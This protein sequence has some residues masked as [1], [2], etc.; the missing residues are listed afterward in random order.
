MLNIHTDTIRRNSIFAFALIAFSG[1]TPKDT[2]LPIE[3]T[4]V[5]EAPSQDREKYAGSK[6]CISCH[7]EIAKRYSK[8]PMSQSAG[9]ISSQYD[10]IETFEERLIEI[11]SKGLVYEV[12]WSDRGEMTHTERTMAENVHQ[13]GQ[14]VAIDFYIGSG[15]RGRSYLVQRD[16]MLFQSPLT[17]YAHEER[18]D[19][20]PGYENNN[21]H[22]DRRISATCI[23]CHFGRANSIAGDPSRFNKTEVFAEFGIGC[24]NCHGPSADHVAWHLDEEKD[25]ALNSDPIL[26]ISSLSSSK[27]N[28][29]C[30]QC[31][32][33][34]ED[35]ILRRNRSSFD[36]R[37]GEELSDTWVCFVDDAPADNHGLSAVSHVEQMQ[38]SVC[39]AKSQGKMTCVSCHDP[40][41]KPADSEAISFY[42]DKCLTCHGASSTQCSKPELERIKISQQ[43]VCADCH[44]PKQKAADVVHT[45][46]TDHRIL[47]AY[48]STAVSSNPDQ[49]VDLVPFNGVSDHLS[50][51]SLDRAT[52]IAT[53][54]YCIQ[55]SDQ[56]TALLLLP[57]LE[58]YIAK[59]PD[60]IEALFTTGSLHYLVRDSLTAQ[61]RLESV[62]S[63]KADHE[64]ALRTLFLMAHESNSVGLGIVYG[65][66]FLQINRW[67]ANVTGRLIHLLGQT[68]N[69]EEA[70]AL[71]KV[72]VERFPSDH[73]IKTWLNNANAF[74]KEKRDSQPP[75]NFRR[76]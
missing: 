63:L 17:W 76:P 46:L 7:S 75:I 60:D 52:M 57:M 22:F 12:N 36:F 2:S 69:L 74:V 56:T 19:L 44:M 41:G 43:D 21:R 4:V 26:K 24:E 62:L 72:A 50:R 31:H 49:L 32:L 51:E 29:V 54:R 58:R 30:Y 28:S 13:Y 59:H 40:H 5:A 73:Q 25:T 1:C 23:A 47:R 37:P 67:D 39:F 3:T 55:E 38:A 64:D 70:I 8:H 27:R 16:D 15:A 14:T 35:R 65:R 42:R 45:S 34:A 6:V 66:R 18:W 71:A 20:S 9:K 61:E 33:V 68:E 48:P 11:R 53:G 10:T